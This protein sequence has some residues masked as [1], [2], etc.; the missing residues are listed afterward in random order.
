MV[1]S[2]RRTVTRQPLSITRGRSATGAEIRVREP[3]AIGAV[4]SGGNGAAHGGVLPLLFGPH[5]GE[6]QST[7]CRPVRASAGSHRATLGADPRPV[8]CATPSFVHVPVAW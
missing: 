5:G 8:G 4:R 1:A 3:T 2:H 7:V 6:Q